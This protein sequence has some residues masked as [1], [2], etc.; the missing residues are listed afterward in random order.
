MA[1]W[2]RDVWINVVANLA[3][4]ALIYLGGVVVGLFPS[5][6]YALVVSGT[7]ALLVLVVGGN[8]VADRVEGKG[9]SS[10]SSPWSLRQV[11]VVAWILTMVAAAVLSPD[12]ALRVLCAVYAVGGVVVL[13]VWQVMTRRPEV[14]LRFLVRVRTRLGTGTDD[15]LAP[16]KPTRLTLLAPT[17]GRG[18]GRRLASATPRPRRRVAGRRRHQNDEVVH[19][20]QRRPP[21][22]RRPGRRHQPQQHRSH[23]HG[24][25]PRPPR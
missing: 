25:A 15:L 18:A 7:V 23:D 6:F 13:L 22:Q 19:D 24:R 3:A 8:L 4:A 17:P 10:T 16:D 9:D 12:P 21:H 2:A 1:R 20:E 11:S 14:A 5:N